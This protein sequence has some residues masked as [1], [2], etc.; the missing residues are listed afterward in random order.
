M[1]RRY[2]GSIEL[3]QAIARYLELR[4]QEM[5]SQARAQER[6]MQRDSIRSEVGQ[7]VTRLLLLAAYAVTLGLLGKAA[8]M[9]AVLFDPQALADKVGHAATAAG[10]YLNLMPDA[11]RG[12]LYTAGTAI[13]LLM[14]RSTSFSARSNIGGA[15]SSAVVVLSLA[16]LSA[17]ASTGLVGSLAALVGFAA[18]LLIMY[19]LL[20]MVRRA[21]GSEAIKEVPATGSVRRFVSVS[22]LERA[23][24]RGLD[25]IRPARNS[26]LTLAFV[27]LPTLTIGLFAAAFFANNRMLFWPAFSAAMALAVWTVWACAATPGASRIPLWSMV[28]WAILLLTQLSDDIVAVVFMAA[29][30]TVLLANVG[31]V[32]LRPRN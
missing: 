27:A 20:Q 23:A 22:E 18:S 1:L 9:R 21:N 25:F 28:I 12:P 26:G 30:I 8:L 29:V 17:A 4:I 5:E 24:L 16:G 19:K 6:Q 10:Q 3:E 13:A 14:L 31:L 11:L 32:T 7:M 15:I 2:K